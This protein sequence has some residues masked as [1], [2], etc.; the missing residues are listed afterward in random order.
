MTPTS[1]EFTVTMPGDARL[2]GA[3]RLL[4]AQA[5]TYAQVPAGAGDGFA[6]QVEQAVQDA[7]GSGGSRVVPIQ[8][9]FSGDDG[10]VTVTIS[11]EAPSAAPAASRSTDGLSVEWSANGSRHTC[12]IRQRLSA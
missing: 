4:A 2:L 11:Y 8:L 1:F 3:I 7:I 6:G 5:A 10:A 12:H 9:G